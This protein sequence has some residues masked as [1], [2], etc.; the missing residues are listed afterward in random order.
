M[1][2]QT[3]GSTISTSFQAA[4]SAAGNPD[5]S[6]GFFST[7]KDNI[8]TNT[9]KNKGYILNNANEIVTENNIDSYI[10]EMDEN[11][12]HKKIIDI[13]KFN[14]QLNQGENNSWDDYFST[15][16]DGEQYLAELIQD[17]TDLSELTGNDLVEANKKARASVLSQ[18]AAL[19]AQTIAAKAS[20]VAMSALS[21]LGN[22][23]VGFLVSKGIELAVSAIDNLIHRQERLAEAA[24]EASEN[25][26]KSYSAFNDTKQSTGKITQE[27]A[28]LSQHVNQTTGENK[29]LSTEEYERFLEL[30]NQLAETFPNIGYTIDENGNKIVGLSGNIDEITQSINGLVQAQQA[31]THQEISNNMDDVYNK[32]YE[33]IK[34]NNSEIKLIEEQKTKIPDIE[35]LLSGDS[36]KFQ[37]DTEGDRQLFSDM[38]EMFKPFGLKLNIEAGSMFLNQDAEEADLSE[39]ELEQIKKQSNKINKKYKEGN[40]ELDNQI[41]N[42]ENENQMTMDS[43]APNITSW[44]TTDEN[45]SNIV[46]SYGNDL[47]IA[48][49]KIVQSIEI[50]EDN[51]HWDN[52]DDWITKNILAPLNNVDND[53]IRHA[54]TELFTNDDLSID[55]AME[56]LSK[57]ED[58]YKKNNYE[59]PDVFKEKKNK[60]S[61]I[62][63]QFDERNDSFQTG[64]I[65][66]LEQFFQDNSIDNADEIEK[67]VSVTEGI[68]DATEAMAKWK[69]LENQEQ[70]N[71]KSFEGAW[72]SLGTTGS[73]NTKQSA[74]EAKEQLLQLAEAGKLTAEELE[75]SPAGQ[76]LLEQTKLSAEE[77]AEKVNSL[78]DA[79]K[80]LNALKAGISPINDVLAQKQENLNHEDTAENGINADTLSGFNAEIKGL[81][82]WK[83]FE[84]TLGNG[85]SSMKECQQAANKLASEWISS[86]NF[87][88]QLNDTN[89]EYY[90]SQLKGMGIDNAQSIVTDILNTKKAEAAEREREIAA[91]KEYNKYSSIDLTQADRAQIDA[92]GNYVGWT[93]E[94]REALYRLAL[95]KQIA[96]GVHLNSQ[97]DIDQLISL[98]D[99]IGGS[100]KALNAWK[101]YDGSGGTAKAKKLWQEA[102]DSVIAASK[103]GKK[104]DKDP[105]VNLSPTDPKSPS[106]T[107]TPAPKQKETKQSFDWLD[108]YVSVLTK[109]IDLLKAK[110]ENL[111]SVN[112]KNRNLAKQIKEVN[113]EIKAYS[114]EANVYAKKARSI[115]LSKNLK[116]KVDNG[117]IKGKKYGQLVKEYGEKDANKIQK[118]MDLKDKSSTAKQNKEQAIKTKRD[119]KIQQRQ[120]RVDYN[121][122]L[123]SKYDAELENTT[124]VKTKIKLEEKKLDAIKKSY[125]HQI[126][127]AKLEN[128]SVKAATLLAQKWK[129]IAD[130]RERILQ[131]KLDENANKRD[132]NNAAYENADNAGKK[133]LNLKNISSLKDDINLYD[134]NVETAQKDVNTA[135]SNVSKAADNVTAQ[136]KKDKLNKSTM[137]EIKSYISSGKKI[138]DVHLEG[139]KVIL[140]ALYKKLVKYNNAID[141]QKN[142]TNILAESQKN[143]DLAIEKDKTEIREIKSNNFQLDIDAATNAQDA[144]SAQYANLTTADDKNKNINAQMEQQKNIHNLKI[145]QLK[146]DIVDPVE[147]Q[148]ALAKEDAEYIAYIRGQEVLQLQNFSE[149]QSAQYELNQQR[150]A[151]AETAKEKNIYEAESRKNLESQYNYEIQIAQK[152]ND[153]A[154]AEKLRL[155][156][157][158]KIEA[159]YQRQIENI[160]EEY[161]LLLD[162]NN[163]RKS[164]IDSKIAALQANGYGIS[165]NLYKMQQKLDQENYSATLKEIND[166][167]QEMKHLH[168][169]ALTKAKIELESLKQQAW[170][171]QK[172]WAE[173]QKTINEINLAKIERIGTMLNYQADNLDYMQEILSHSDFTSSDKEIGGLT[174]EGLAN[175]ALTFAKMGNNNEQIANIYDQIAEKQR[176]LKAGE[177][178]DN[179]DQLTAEL[180][181][182]IQKARELEK[183][184]YDSGESIK[185]ML[186]DSL[187]SLSSAL[188]ENI[189]KYKEALQT[190]KDLYDY[191]KKMADQLKSIASL[192]KQLAA[193][194]GS[195][196]EEARARIQKLQIQLE[197]E[198]QNLKEMEYDKYIQDQ[199]EMLDKVSSDFQDFIANVSE[200]SVSEICQAMSDAVTDNMEEINTSIAEA[201]AE[202]TKIGEVASSIQGLSHIIEGLD[203]AGKVSTTTD[204]N[205]NVSYEFTDNNGNKINTQVNTRGTVTG[206][207][208]N[209]KDISLPDKKDTKSENSSTPNTER[210]IAL[211][212]ERI[213]RFIN[214]GLTNY[215]PGASSRISSDKL[216]QLLY[217][218][219]HKMATP[220]TENQLL[221]LLNIPGD[222]DDPAA[223]RRAAEELKALGFSQGGIVSKLNKIAFANGDDGWATLKR[224]ESVLTPAQTE[225]FRKLT[226]NL[227]PLNAIAES[228][229]TLP[230]NPKTTSHPPLSNTTIRSVDIH[231]DGSNVLDADSF[232]RTLHNPRVLQEVS[233]GVSSQIG[234]AMSNRFG[235]F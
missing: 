32:A 171:Y 36:I 18:N 153:L 104:K 40:K 11:S 38:Q 214:H 23:A 43:F 128:N 182:L 97:D 63:N 61:D 76:T 163:A 67:W 17:T 103:K 149:E 20:K 120:N 21:S 35:K 159:S 65:G 136:M 141:A 145:E 160:K 95:Q 209:G 93:E 198:Q 37:I 125:K 69:E 204:S 176:Q 28:E 116:K 222:S 186:I 9:R 58:Y 90:V 184:N 135:K 188:D 133:N 78:A 100:T 127:I 223:L 164:T 161:S 46:Q 19:K 228:M 74:L 79:S 41:K 73:D 119:L 207:S 34:N 71:P 150:E 231:L 130:S 225:Q 75:K 31:L 70:K 82:S 87:L 56:Y 152:N 146:N 24:K 197:N 49:Q 89:E 138:P 64:N 98:V 140:P 203:F 110:L 55:S 193:L 53:E 215:F 190:Q 224:G 185:S 155:E 92:L 57:T 39:K 191:R 111:F 13:K 112:A 144:L 30:S 48:M 22:M 118:Y 126:N 45:Y 16:G 80:Q 212:K 50:D 234:N 3:L 147:L 162:M 66:G 88:S 129:E 180:N 206:V 137:K 109:K 221:R 173:I 124:N 121:D 25:I 134:K 94:T 178:V 52:M 202:S 213:R 235:N 102:K 175:A 4:K 216:N 227:V 170:D 62:Q 107:P 200:Q 1:S 81:K 99:A 194:Q 210:D 139:T 205:G 218:N 181:E 154:L 85:K 168:G 169:D 148:N 195:D 12:A 189:S 8:I 131:Y 15:L 122:S 219:Y 179:G 167:S 174:T 91:E 84:Q 6:A 114:K 192:E 60:L 68:T 106:G 5:Q 226:A 151:N 158:E 2:F 201:F 187:N 117:Q 233:N 208:V 142:A 26:E 211:L 72:D 143:R 157:E 83:D 132:Y 220:E 115:N 14:T 165:T 172:S 47:G 232:I 229:A 54:Y 177:Y 51:E 105:I 86:N 183:A 196:T 199:E 156:Q 59:L 29:D 7:F 166:V 10:P 27:F 108:R 230:N 123:K 33:D 101:N 42:L 96:N 113:K 217:T 44:L 77:A